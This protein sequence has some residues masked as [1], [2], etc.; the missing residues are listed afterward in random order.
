MELEDFEKT[1]TN[2]ILSTPTIEFWYLCDIERCTR[3]RA[4]D[5]EEGKGKQGQAGSP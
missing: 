3:G 4:S 5:R 1:D 2:I